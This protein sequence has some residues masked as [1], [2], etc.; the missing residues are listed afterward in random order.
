MYVTALELCGLITAYRERI[1]PSEDDW[2]HVNNIMNST[3]HNFSQCR[4][5][6]CIWRYNTSRYAQVRGISQ[7]ASGAHTLTLRGR[8]F[9]CFIARYSKTRV[10]YEP[11][12][13]M[14]AGINSPPLRRTSRSIIEFGDEI[15]KDRYSI[16]RTNLGI[17]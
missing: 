10:A 7:V 5:S 4:L 1:I 8:S 13:T 17:I 6:P 16:D 3:N 12:R 9:E 11:H 2:S 14:Q 15:K